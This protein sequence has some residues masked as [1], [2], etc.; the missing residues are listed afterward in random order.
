VIVVGGYGNPAVKAYSYTGS[1][2]VVNANP[3]AGMLTCRNSMSPSLYGI[4]RNNNNKNSN[5]HHI[6]MHGVCMWWW[7]IKIMNV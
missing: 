6:I 2:A 4:G 1:S 5:D 3:Q 7:G